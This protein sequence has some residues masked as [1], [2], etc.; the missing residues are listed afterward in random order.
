MTGISRPSSTIVD[1]NKNWSN[2]IKIKFRREELSPV[3]CW[4]MNC[5]ITMISE[6]YFQVTV[7]FEKKMFACLYTRI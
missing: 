5:V 1:T 3:Q 2:D 4:K 7:V 6:C